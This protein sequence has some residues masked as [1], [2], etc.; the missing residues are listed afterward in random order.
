MESWANAAFTAFVLYTANAKPRVPRVV[1]RGE[2]AS[3]PALARD[4]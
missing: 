4:W 2:E 3:F 1:L